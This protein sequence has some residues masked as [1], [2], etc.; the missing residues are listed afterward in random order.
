MI[1]NNSLT[2]SKIEMRSTQTYNQKALVK[3]HEN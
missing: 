1:S 3:L 2:K